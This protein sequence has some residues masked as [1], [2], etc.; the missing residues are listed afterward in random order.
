[1]RRLD[2]GAS[3]QRNNVWMQC[4]VRAGSATG[5]GSMRRIVT[6]TGRVLGVGGGCDRRGACAY[7]LRNAN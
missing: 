6:A 1:M 5:S 3:G 4:A 2:R 7:G